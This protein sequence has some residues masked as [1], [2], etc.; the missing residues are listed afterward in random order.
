MKKQ[1][2]PLVER[3]L[4]TFDLKLVR[5]SMNEP[6][7]LTE[8]NIPPEYCPYYA[9]I[10]PFITNVN[11]VDG[12]TNR[13]F[14]LTGES[15]DPAVFAIRASLDLGLSGKDLYENILGILEQHKSLTGCS[16]AAEKLG[17]YT[18]T[19]RLREFPEWADVNPWDSQSVEEKFAQFPQ[20]VKGNRG[21]HGLLI[22]TD[23]SEEIMRIAQDLSLPSHAMQYAKLTEK[24]KAN[25]FR[26]GEAY[27]YVTAE[28]L[29]KNGQVRW[30]PG[31]DGNHRVAVVS[32]LGNKSIPVLVTRIINYEHHRFWPN[33]MN[34]TFEESSAV[35][36][37]DSIFYARTPEHQRNWIS[38]VAKS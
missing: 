31:G 21:D 12:R 26:Y 29:V 8:L 10:Q 16:N 32:A 6:R 7:D 28:I 14:D 1:I 11:L 25:G 13:W 18:E 19:T 3:L 30:K 2:K 22:E 5:A 33:V 23:N 34:G 24:I 4:H 36:V 37:F 15:L 17:L 38:H 27:G 35:E 20:L 9:G